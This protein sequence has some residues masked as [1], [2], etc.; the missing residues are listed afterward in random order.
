MRK[1]GQ[2]EGSIYRR[3]DGRWAATIHLGYD[4]G[5]RRRKTFYGQSRG[6]VAQ[7]LAEAI[8]LTMDGVPIP[9]ERQTVGQFLLLWLDETVKPTVRMSTHRGYEAKLRVH[10]IPALGRLPL[11]KLTPQRVQGFLNDKFKAGLAAQTVQHLRTIL[12]AALN[13]AVKW[14]LVMRNSAAL[15]DGPRGPRSEV[16]LV[17]PSQARQLLEAFRGDRLEA[18]YTVA[19]AVGLRQGEALGLRWQDIDLEARTLTV[20]VA[21]ERAEGHFRLTEPKTDRSR[22]TIALPDVAIRALKAHRARQSQE[23]LLAGPEWQ[24]SWDL[25][26]T[27][28]SGA[29]LH[30][31]NV[32]RGFR[33]VLERASLPSQRFHDLRHACASLLIVQGIH[34]RV[35]METLGHS[36]IGLTMDTYGHVIPELQRDAADKMDVL[37]ASG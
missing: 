31:T 3:K 8:K 27:S 6:V 11:V 20:C 2:G 13:D 16:R 33:Q 23:R 4:G 18:L 19:L 32:T 37:L 14:G 7:R 30:G 1:R 34:P 5:R 12:R 9:S 28:P 26:F 17:N 22:R 15:V 25:V 35:I 24:D 21:L 36:R 10:V 29:P